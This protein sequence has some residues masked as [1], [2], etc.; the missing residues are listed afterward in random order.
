[1]LKLSLGGSVCVDSKC[2]NVGFKQ[3]AKGIINHTVSLHPAH[4]GEGLRDHRNIKVAFSI[5]GAL[6]PNVQ[7]TLVLDQ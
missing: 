5:P 6:V 2:V 1:M 4:A 7:L 3:V